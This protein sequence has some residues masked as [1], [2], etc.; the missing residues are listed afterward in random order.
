MG[1]SRVRRVSGMAPT[2][3]RETVARAEL[4]GTEDGTSSIARKRFD[5]LAS[6]RSLSEVTGNRPPGPSRSSTM[7]P[8]EGRDLA[9]RMR[10][11]Q[12]STSSDGGA[13][14][15]LGNIR[16]RARTPTGS[17]PSTF[18]QAKRTAS[19]YF[20]SLRGFTSLPTLTPP[21]PSPPLAGSVR[22]FGANGDGSSSPLPSHY[23]TGLGGKGKGKLISPTAHIVISRFLDPP[24][25]P[26]VLP[27]P[28]PSTT[29]T[30]NLSTTTSSE[31]EQENIPPPAAATQPKSA[32]N[33]GMQKWAQALVREAE[34]IERQYR[35]VDKWRDPLG[36]SLERV[37][38]REKEGKELALGGTGTGGGEEGG[39]KLAR[40]E[41]AK[42]GE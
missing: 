37:L 20:A 40:G 15:A 17:D 35:A 18:T 31:Q 12:G 2:L 4:I 21:S 23:P 9:R 7:G 27:T 32:Q 3:D 16:E 1:P 42:R 22:Y 29:T 36:E 24:A 13:I 10:L 39:R 14:A 6:L 33:E 11:A 41:S 25:S 38:R 8:A 26:L 34:R 5:S 28:L 19:G 30:N